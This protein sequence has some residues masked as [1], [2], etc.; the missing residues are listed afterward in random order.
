M[1]QENNPRKISKVGIEEIDRLYPQRV[2]Y[3]YPSMYSIIGYDSSGYMVVAVYPIPNQARNIYYRYKYRVTE[4]SA[5]A[6]TPIIPLR[7]RWVLVAG[8]VYQVA[9]YLDMPDIAQNYERQY[10]QGIAQL[11]GADKKIDERI[12]KGIGGSMDSGTFVGSNYPL[13][14]D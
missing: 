12:I 11:V 1:R 6:N 2:S 3:G 4:M 5:D 8:A 10:R 7:Y 9:E 14:P 13:I